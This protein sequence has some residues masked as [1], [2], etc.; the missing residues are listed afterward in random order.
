MATLLHDGTA[1]PSP[2]LP[3]QGYQGVFQASSVPMWVYDLETL[4]FLA[5]NNAAVE[6]Y[7]YSRSEFLAMTIEDIR[8]VEDLEALRTAVERRVHGGTQSRSR[9]RHRIKD[10]TLIDVEVNGSPVT[11]Q[12][13]S[14]GLVLVREPDET[15]RQA[16]ELA[17]FGQWE[18]DVVTNRVWWSDTL[19]EIFG[20]HSRTFEPSYEAYLSQVHPED[21]ELAAAAVGKTLRSDEPFV[22]EHRIVLPDGEIRWVHSR[23]RL[24]RDD[25]GQPLRLMGVCQD[26]T[27]Q[28]TT[29]ETLTRL[30]LLDPLTG[31]ANRAL[32][33]DR[34]ELALRRR[35]LTDGTMAGVLFIDLDRFKVVND[36]LGHAAGD[37][38]LIAVA[39]RLRDVV[40]VEDTIA[41]LGGDE[42]AI[43][44]DRMA[45]PVAATRIAQRI[46]VSLTAPIRVEDR[47]V[48]I[49]AS[50]GIAF[51]EAGATAGTLVRDADAAM[52]QAKEKGRNRHEIYDPAIRDKLVLRATRAEEL[53]S[54]LERQEL[55]VL[56]QPEVDLV[57]GAMVGIEALV[58]W[59][60]P[61]LGLVPPSDFIEVAEDTGLIVPLGRWVLMHACHELARLSEVPGHEGLCLSVNLSARELGE[62]GLITTVR[63]ALAETGIDPA[64]LC[65]E[66]TETVLMDDVDSSIHALHALKAL[67]VRL[68]IDDFGTG[69]SSLSY[70][71]RFPVDVVKL[72]R[73]FVSGLG[74]D[75]AATAIVAA[76]VNLSHALGLSVVAEG[77]ETPEQLVVLR[78]LRC[79]RGQGY[80]WSR[81]LPPAQ[82]VGPDAGPAG[83]LA[84][85]P[86]DVHTTLMDRVNALRA[87]TGRNVVVQAPSGLASAFGQS[88][89]LQSVLDQLLA[90]AVKYSD[91]DRPVVVSA[92]ADRRWVRVSVADYGI[93]MSASDAIRCFEQFWQAEAPPGR[94]R[95][96]TGIGLYIVRSLVEAMGG[97]VAVKTALGKGATF[98]IALPR[99][100]QEAAR[101]RS[102]LASLGMGEDTSIREFMRHIGVPTRR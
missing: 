67:G 9:W 83:S 24:S 60:H 87:A 47:E 45:D 40:R 37:Q 2:D 84:L 25:R 96:G 49:S 93:G 58:R 78:A 20:L 70:L 28:K 74:T 82:L 102:A 59:Q 30:A 31:L 7:G 8:P 68:A 55:R 27:A 38:L 61:R 77:V 23:G 4:R 91:A 12:G 10:G 17:R 6:R 85:V 39:D 80:H 50:I 46:L 41:R 66:I 32:F 13:R 64:R 63:A 52:Y 73:S 35:D 98:T 81:P 101:G 43:V 18:W 76:A 72:D 14:A 95:Q 1:T 5:V 36:T 54:A 48:V 16:Q 26:V 92:A 79:D 42:F 99:S 57:S 29:E 90:N 21:R 56:Y 62:P 3:E 19:Y 51:G 89:A 94:H 71:R 11:F 34:L 100:A 86:V 22:S 75:P 65:L 33:M 44:C 15:I 88:E 53:R 97:H 69:Y